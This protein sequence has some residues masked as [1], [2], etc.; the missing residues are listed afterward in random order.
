MAYYTA[1]Y[2]CI[3]Y[4]FRD[5]IVAGVAHWAHNSKYMYVVNMNLKATKVK[6]ARNNT[7]FVNRANWTVNLNPCSARLEETTNFSFFYF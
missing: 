2:V 5:S 6:C 3:P 1:I 7:L 4:I